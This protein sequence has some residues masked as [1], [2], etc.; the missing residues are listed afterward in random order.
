MEIKYK[1]LWFS[2]HPISADQA[3]EIGKFLVLDERATAMAS[4]NLTVDNYRQVAEELVAIANGHG[5]LY[6][7]GVFPALIMAEAWDQTIFDIEQ[8]GGTGDGRVVLLAAHNETRSAE[9][10]KPT[11]HHGG[12]FSVGVL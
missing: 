4:M 6:I 7:A 2:R 10:G 12:F 8:R 9:G 3:A 11:F 1:T 5:C